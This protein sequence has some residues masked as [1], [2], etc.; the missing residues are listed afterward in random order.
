MKIVQSFWSKPLRQCTGPAASNTGACGWP[1]KKY[2]YFSWALSSL[3]FRKYYDEV[4]LITDKAGHDLLIDKFQL[5]YTSVNIVLDDL[6]EYDPDLWAIG[7]IY[8][9]SIQT[10][11]FIH[12]DGDVII[13][14]KFN[15]NF[16]NSSLLCQ[17]KEE[18]HRLD[19]MYWTTFLSVMQN[20][21]YY[22]AVL[23][24]SISRNNCIKAINAGIIGGHN[25]RFFR[26]YV[27]KAFEFVDKN[28]AHL[29]KVNKGAFNII[30]EQFLFHAL[31]EEEQEEINYFDTTTVAFHDYSGVP[32]K[33]KYIHAPGTRK[34]EKYFADWLEYTLHAMYPKY[35]YKIVN[36]LKTGQV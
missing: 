9:Y 31:C 12:A 21:E 23:N 35:Y 20:F 24:K 15:E 25:I 29:Y 26:E 4:E 30:F 28:I 7:K 17:C 11:P 1:D 8:A 33:T 5:P 13:W 10:G 14:E 16:E 22:P 36:L 3:Q 32:S 34:Q 18:E 27:K 19:N 6:N 2:N